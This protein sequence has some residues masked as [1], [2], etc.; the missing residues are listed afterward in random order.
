MSEAI[1]QTYEQSTIVRTAMVYDLDSSLHES[2][3]L[4]SSKL[5]IQG[6]IIPH[7]QI[8]ASQ[9][10]QIKLATN[11]VINPTS[12]QTLI[13]QLKTIID[14]ETF[15]TL[16]CCGSEAVSKYEFGQL[17]CDVFNLDNDYL[18]PTQADNP[19]RPENVS[20]ATESS[21]QRLDMTFPTLEE[22][23]RQLHDRR[24]R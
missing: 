2:E 17:I 23:L 18:N 20:L 9:G 15:G 11:E 22:Q 16:H 7:L 12:V 6:E 24:T 14:T 19:I 1:L 13:K 5:L 21:E 3:Y 8:R 10:K 4:N